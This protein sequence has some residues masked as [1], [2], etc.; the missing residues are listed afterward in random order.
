MKRG[1]TEKCDFEI[2]KNTT[3]VITHMATNPYQNCQIEDAANR[4]ILKK[5]MMVFC[6]NPV[7]I[8]PKIS[9]NHSAVLVTTTSG[10][11]SQIQRS[12]ANVLPQSTS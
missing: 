12:L 10:R 2:L 4:C 5:G 8:D 3:R 9:T 11:H 7:I 6:I 1:E